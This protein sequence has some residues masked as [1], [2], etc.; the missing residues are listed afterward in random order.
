MRET[1]RNY[2]NFQKK[3]FIWPAYKPLFPVLNSDAIDALAAL[4][5]ILEKV[6]PLNR[7]HRARLPMDIVEL[8][9]L[10]TQERSLLNQSYW[11]KPGFVSAYLYYYLPWNIIRQCRLLSGLNLPYKENG[12]QKIILDAGSGCLSLPIALW[13]AR[14]DLRKA[15][16]KIVSFDKVRRPLELGKKIYNLLVEKLQDKGW[17]VKIIKSSIENA[18][19]EIGRLNDKIWLYSAANIINEYRSQKER[20]RKSQFFSSDFFMDKDESDSCLSL[21]LDAIDK[22]MDEE[23]VFL[24]I[25]PGTRLGGSSLMELRSIALQRNYFIHSP[26]THQNVCPLIKRD[27]AQSDKPASHAS[28][29]CHFTFDTS[30]T[31]AWLTELTKNAEMNKKSLSLSLL[32]F[33]KNKPEIFSKSDTLPCRILSRAF[34][35]P[36]ISSFCR[37][38]CEKR[39]LA[40]L[41]ESSLLP[42]GAL[43]PIKLPEHPKID[44]KSGAVLIQPCNG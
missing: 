43:L 39:G 4:P 42:S 35:I 5:E 32:M 27:N 18:D 12:A 29:W 44:K 37:Y 7:R 40:V 1:G 9:H 36:G 22:L 10:L 23:T 6:W 15:S 16:I 28:A 41:A 11:D 17:P 34:K 38:A 30:K 3:K 19:K 31:P 13:L 2:S 26:C 20:A 8:S 14:A 33:S 25:E 24:G 21:F